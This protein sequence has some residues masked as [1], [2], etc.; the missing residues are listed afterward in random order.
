ME[1]VES[2]ML[3]DIVHQVLKYHPEFMLLSPP[4][5]NGGTYELRI[6]PS[7]AHETNTFDRT[8]L[9]DDLR[10]QLYG[11]GVEVLT[12]MSRGVGLVVHVR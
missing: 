11:R 9:E 12:V 3:S 5:E 10:C 1:L 8:H 2:T 4:I 6:G 7:P